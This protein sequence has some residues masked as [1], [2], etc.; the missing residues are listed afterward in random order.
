MSAGIRFSGCTQ[1][2]EANSDITDPTQKNSAFDAAEKAIREIGSDPWFDE[3]TPEW[4]NFLVSNTVETFE[5]YAVNLDQ[6]AQKL[7]E[8]YVEI[9]L[10]Y[11][12]AKTM[13]PWESNI[14]AAGA[15]PSTDM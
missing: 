7:I 5:Q 13:N 3:L 11:P 2:S 10:T 6:A 9:T 8:F 1:L 14:P 15:V 4:Q 12:E